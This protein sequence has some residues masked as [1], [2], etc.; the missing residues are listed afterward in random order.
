MN[1]LENTVLLNTHFLILLAK[2][3][4]KKPKMKHI[5]IFYV[6]QIFLLLLMQFLIAKQDLQASAT[7]WILE[8][9]DSNDIIEEK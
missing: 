6:K 1:L 7:S 4:N 3:A 9:T 5:L 8:Y 2:E